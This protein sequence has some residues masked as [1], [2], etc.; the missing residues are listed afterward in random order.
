MIV[1]HHLGREG[2]SLNHK[3][4]LPVGLLKLATWHQAK[5]NQVALSLGYLRTDF[6]A[7]EV[8]VTSLFTYWADHV[9]DAVLHYR[10][11]LPAARITVGGIYASLQPDHCREY[12]GCDAVWRGVHEGAERCRPDYSLVDTDFQIIHASRGCIRRCTFLS[13]IHI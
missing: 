9:R 10:C 1:S 6:E 7:D 11:C 2:K 8:Y 3:D 4:Y 5:G 12:T 13:L